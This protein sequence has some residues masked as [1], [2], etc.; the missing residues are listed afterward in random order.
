MASRVKSSCALAVVVALCGLSA[1]GR[2]AHAGAIIAKK[3][4]TSTVGDPQFVYDFEIDLTAGS[5]LSNQGFITI[6]DIPN[7]E[8]KLTSQPTI[9]GA[10][11]QDFGK[12]PLNTPPIID[13]PIPNV[14]WVYNGTAITN[15]TTSDMDLGTFTIGV[16]FPLDTPPSPLLLFVGSLDGSTFSNLGFVQV[17]AIPEPSSVAL[18]LTGVSALLLFWLRGK[19]QAQKLKLAAP[20]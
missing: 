2:G 9:W 8:T 10:S 20:A 5:T 11:V 12:T 13:T 1:G 7:L 14:T 18:L 4:T 15:N 3:G 16:T 6:Y 19:T 17:N